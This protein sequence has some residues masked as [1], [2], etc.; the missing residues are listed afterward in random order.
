[1]SSWSPPTRR[2][3]DVVEFMVQRGEEPSRLSDVAR[4]LDLN[5]A[6]AYAILQE[7]CAGGWAIR[8][9]SNKTFTLGPAFSTMA[10]QLEQTQ[11]LARSCSA[12]AQTL[13]EK[14]GFAAS[15]SERLNDLLVVI[16]F[17]GVPDTPLPMSSGDQLPFVAPFGPCFAAWDG[18]EERQQWVSRGGVENAA[19]AAQLEDYLSATRNRGF[20]VERMTAPMARAMQAMMQL[21]A[22]AISDS[23]RGH[24]SGVL[25]EITTAAALSGD[26]EAVA[27]PVG[28]L[29]APVFDR[30]GRVALSIA[31]HPFRELS[32]QQI[33][34]IGRQVDRHARAISIAPP[35]RS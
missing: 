26:E 25:T 24:I 22:E 2:V 20:S 3:L 18:P 12:A 8:D 34:R 9:P 1:M 19:L 27:P 23:M 21:H 33:E 13:A 29:A 31:V 7:L 30:H 17:V 10:R 16:D 4:E 5:Q 32:A 6:T 15:V 28:V 35:S 14:T 11:P